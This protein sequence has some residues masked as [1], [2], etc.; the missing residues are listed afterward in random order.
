MKFSYLTLG[1]NRWPGF[2]RDD[3]KYYDDYLKLARE[4]DKLDY[5]TLWTGE[6][7]FAHV[8][9]VS[10]PTVLLSA[11]AAQTERIRL[12][13]AVNVLPF[14]HPVRYAE[15]L[16]TLDVISGGRA[17]IGAG[18][19]YAKGEF[20][21]FEIDMSEARRRTREV[22]TIARSAL[23]TGKFGV[24]GEF[25]KTLPH[26]ELVPAPIQQPFPTYVAL[27]GSWETVEWAA[28]N[29]H[30]LIT[31][32][33]SPATTK[34]SLPKTIQVFQEIRQDSGH[35]VG[36]VAV[37]FFT[38]CSTDEEKI[39][40]EF[41]R[42]VDYWR[43]LSEDLDATLPPHLAYWADLKETFAGLTIEQL[44]NRQTAFGRPEKLIE[45]FLNVAASGVDEICIESFYGPQDIDEAIENAKFLRE[46]VMPYVDERF[47]GPKYGWDPEQRKV[48]LQKDATNKM[49][50]IEI[51][52]PAEVE[53]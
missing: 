39:E 52:E 18:V 3:V 24:S 13:T 19:G 9:A 47:G 42:M 2:K 14:H 30:N 44:H 27:S 7:H 31:G 21:G 5:M 51:P 4:L 29:N 46:A 6:H 23:D 8:A 11:I 49:D 48:V 17:Q 15:D 22:L 32:S 53:D 26:L 40:Q 38:L 45:L 36:K 34:K 28:Q 10:S 25:F 35:S 20:D 41:Q 33:Q 12:A 50:G 43:Y 37:P 1:E 16:S